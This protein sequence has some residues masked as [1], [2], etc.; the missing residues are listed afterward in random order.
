MKQ[1]SR[2]GVYGICCQEDKLLLVLK[3]AGPYKGS[4]DL[5]GGAIEFGESP[6]EA[7]KREFLE[8]T[9]LRFEKVSFFRNLSHLG[10]FDVQGSKFHHIGL[11]YHVFNFSQA[12]GITPEDTFYWVPF[13]ELHGKS[14]TPF[15]K[16]AVNHLSNL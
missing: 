12:D 13:E 11:I 9:A 1:I 7:L 2:L 10:P 4:L 5:P 14:L 16:V 15:A 3:E 6:E 8:E